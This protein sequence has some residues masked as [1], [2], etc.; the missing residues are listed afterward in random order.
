M[1]SA[2]AFSP[3]PD[4]TCRQEKDPLEATVQAALAATTSL[5][6]CISP[7]PSP[8]KNDVTLEPGVYCG[9]LKIQAG[10][11]VTLNPGTYVIRNGAFYVSAGAT[12]KGTDVTIV[13]A[14]STNSTYFANQGGANIDLKAPTSGPFSGILMT[15][16]TDSSPAPHENTIT[17]GGDMKF[18]GI[19]YF[20][21]QPLSIEGNGDIGDTANQFAIMADTIH[22]QGTGLLTVHL[23][24]DYEAVGFPSLPESHERVR[25]AL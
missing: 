23:T 21:K 25:L 15:Q 12:L 11:T 1:A 7:N 5:T 8:V 3:T 2:G 17:G 9:G 19:M 16:T 4:N 13:L 18:S 22:V 10:P 6:D 14:G 20:P 24:S